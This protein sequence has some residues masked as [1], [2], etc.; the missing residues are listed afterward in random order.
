MS[1][2]FFFSSYLPLPKYLQTS[3][4]IAKIETKL[5]WH[6]AIVR[7]VMNH[8]TIMVVVGVYVVGYRNPTNLTQLWGISGIR[9]GHSK[10]LHALEEGKSRDC[11]TNRKEVGRLI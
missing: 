6:Q 2:I 8:V 9:L 4:F 7:E 10:P 5:E 11:G 3:I 1:L